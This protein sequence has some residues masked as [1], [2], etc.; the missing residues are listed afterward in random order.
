M[1][2]RRVESRIGLLATTAVH[3]YLSETDPTFASDR[4]LLRINEA[5]RRV[6]IAL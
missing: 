1:G 2:D 6:L 3:W 5:L 4:Y